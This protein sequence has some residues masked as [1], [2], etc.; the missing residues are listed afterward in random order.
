MAFVESYELVEK[1]ADTGSGSVWKAHD[2]ELDRV[3]ALKQVDVASARSLD[4]LRAEAATLARLPHPNIVTVY[5]LVEQPDRVWLVEEWVEGTTLPA[6]LTGSGRLTAKQA[7]GVVRGALLGLSFAHERNIVHRDISPHNIMLDVTGTSKLID[8]GLA[9]PTGIAGVGGT[10][11]YL[12]PQ[13]ARGLAV[14]ARDDVYSCAA[15]LAM[16]LRGAPL[17]DGPTAE[18]VIEEQLRSP[19]PDLGTISR[20]V[21]DVLGRALAQRAEDRYPTASEL[22]AALEDAAERDFGAGW[23]GQASVAALV[24]SGLTGTTA[25]TVH[26]MT[27][28]S[29]PARSA[30]QPRR[31]LRNAPAR[32][33]VV[34]ATAVIIVVA[35]ASIAIALEHHSAGAVA[36]PSAIPPTRAAAALAVPRLTTAAAAPVDALKDPCA[37]LTETQVLAYATAQAGVLGIPVSGPVTPSEEHS[38]DPDLS[39]QPH[40]RECDFTLGA[41]S[42]GAGGPATQPKVIV[43]IGRIG[44]P[45]STD[46]N[47]C[48]D[49]LGVAS[50]SAPTPLTAL[51]GVG[52]GAFYSDLIGTGCARSATSYVVVTQPWL[53]AGPDAAELSTFRSQ[54]SAV[55]TEVLAAADA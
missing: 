39:G 30:K 13:A 42:A 11:G 53:S 47:N 19:R 31:F 50:A 34:G 22:L 29:T 1:V 16:L 45:V 15:V 9:A 37:L 46:F 5:G 51:P 3:V 6:V 35:V 55:L 2:T 52:A 25:A 21:R 40:P 24:T 10:P 27:D 12:S 44:Y 26:A 4:S 20:H 8:F 32:L 17:F 23:L 7:V 41:A 49:S 54:M 14:T 33:V 36:I 48:P 18:S 43:K 28:A 38:V